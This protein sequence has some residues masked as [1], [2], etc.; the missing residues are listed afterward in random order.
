VYHNYVI[1]KVETRV[2]N[3]GKIWTLGTILR[4]KQ[5]Y[6]H[7]VMTRAWFN[8]HL[9]RLHYTADTSLHCI[10]KTSYKT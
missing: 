2:T 6:R 8:N 3:L 4:T 10:S 1:L 9:E 5:L 7:Y